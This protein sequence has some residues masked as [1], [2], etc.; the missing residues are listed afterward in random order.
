M[1]RWV[2]L[3]LVLWSSTLS[4]STAVQPV[5]PIHFTGEGISAPLGEKL[6]ILEDTSATMDI[7]DVLASGRFEHSHSSV[8]NLGIS[9]S[10]FWIKAVVI[11]TSPQERVVLLVDH[12]EIEELDIYLD[13]GGRIEH[14]AHGG[15]LR[16]LNPDIQNSPSFSFVLPIPYGGMADIYIRAQSHKQLQMPLFLQ[17]DRG[18]SDLKLN[19]NLFLGGYIGIMLVMLLYNLFIYFSIRER[20]YLFYVFYL[21]TVCIT[22][23]S[24][25]GYSAFYLW[26]DSYWIIQHSS[27]SFTVI[28]MIFAAE[29][30]QRFVHVNEHIR[31]FKWVKS[32]IYAVAISGAAICF[33]GFAVEGYMVIQLTSAVMAFYMLYIS[34]ALTRMGQRQARYFLVAWSVFVTGI[35]I[36]VAKDWGL[37]PYNDATKHMMA[38]GSAVEV[39]LISFG[40]ADKINVLRREKEQSQA[41][42][43]RMAR[44]NER[45]IRDQNVV[46]ERKV[47]ERTQ[48]LQESND[49]LK[50]TQS[51]LVSAEKMASLGQLTA[52]IAHEINNPLNFISSNIPPLKRDL[53]DL[54]VVLD[55]YRAASK[56]DPGMADVHALEERI[57]VDFTVKEVQ[58]ILGCMENGAARTSEIIRGLRTFS[59]LDEDDLKEA[60][61]NDGLRSTVVVLGP[62]FRDM[63]DVEYDLAELPRVECYPGKLNQ[64]FMNLLNNAAH[65]AKQRHG[66]TGGIVGITSRLEG[67]TVRVSITDNG[68]GMDENVQARLFEPFFTTKNVGEGTGLGLSIAQGIAQKHQ[69]SITLESVV[70]QGTTFT[71]TLPVRRSADYA[72]SA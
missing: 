39:V 14:I 16:P 12:P 24:F 62:Q 35:L 49:H 51:Q 58:E 21:I 33:F 27:T 6:W 18:S 50:Q 29:F 61:I 68:M 70:G 52:G 32:I 25:T 57:G 64:L 56:D 71:L 47:T 36:F 46:L 15:H 31:N 11:N 67:E 48:A 38:I 9:R 55:A 7:R 60:D 41:E 59:R 69:G 4:A 45:F 65:A 13:M 72:K 66:N 22:Q 19:R 53:Q 43:L 26:P 63:V 30:M 5:D 20:N 23:L 3:P 54:K 34:I 1:K 37:L 44:E 42:A 28:T 10:A 17:N 8:P 40:L 2:L